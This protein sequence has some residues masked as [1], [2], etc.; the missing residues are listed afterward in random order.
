MHKQMSL[1]MSLLAG[2]ALAAASSCGTHTLDKAIDKALQVSAAQLSSLGEVYYDAEKFPRSWDPS[3]GE[4]KDFSY[5]DWTCGFYPG[6]LWLYYEMTG[7]EQYKALAEHF[8]DKVKDVPMMTHTHDVGFMVMCSYGHKYAVEGDEASREA[9]IQAARSLSTRYNPEIGLTRSWSFGKKWNYPVII[10]NMM[11]LE[12]LFK[13][14]ELTGEESFRDIALSHADK[15]MLNH[16]RDD[17][18]TWH[19]V[20]YNDDGTVECKNTHQGYSDDSRWSRGQSWGLYGYT[21]C[22]RFTGD[23]RYLDQAVGIAGLIMS[24]PTMPADLIP[25]W[26]YDAPGIPDEPRDA[27]A[28]AIT[29]SALLELQGMVDEPL[30]ASYRDY[31]C[32]ILSSLCSKAYLSEPGTN[33]YFILKHSTGAAS[34]GSEID[35]AINYADY[36]FLEAI[37]RYKSL[38]ANK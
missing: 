9:I 33:G 19:V 2:F 20:S 15:T 28:A 14:S 1:I 31:A 24:L 5:R 16:F 18:S 13:A 36:Y 37:K 10:D 26:D 27:S 34:L 8:T 35:V 3:T 22:Y 38:E 29:A 6:C 32:K 23:K 21:M 12:L 4:Y 17:Y 11:N 25:Y 7:D 30:A